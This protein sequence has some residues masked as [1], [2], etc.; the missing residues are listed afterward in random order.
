MIILVAPIYRFLVYRWLDLHSLQKMASVCKTIHGDE[1]RKKVILEKISSHFGFY[2]MHA[3][4]HDIY[5]LQMEKQIQEAV[6]ENYYGK[7]LNLKI[8]LSTPPNENELLYYKKDLFCLLE[9][10][11]K[12]KILDFYF[13]VLQCIANLNHSL[14]IKWTGFYYLSFCDIRN[15]FLYSEDVV[16][17]HIV[18]CILKFRKPELFDDCVSM[19]HFIQ[20]LIGDEICDLDRIIEIAY[21]FRNYYE[22]YLSLFLE[23]CFESHIDIDEDDWLSPPCSRYIETINKLEKNLD[24]PSAKFPNQ[25]NAI[26]LDSLLAECNLFDVSAIRVANERRLNFINDTPITICFS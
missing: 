1:N 9:T 18:E 13:Q 21:Y 7:T 5:Y 20:D 3:L 16:R 2:S 14:F 12:I 17:T 19:N 22:R 10:N 25:T 4:E 15:M 24:L 6:V 26:V 23:C 11:Q 8:D